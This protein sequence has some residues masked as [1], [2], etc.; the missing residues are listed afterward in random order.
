MR[1]DIPDQIFIKEMSLQ[2]LIFGG[3]HIC[4]ILNK[5]FLYVTAL[6]LRTVYHYLNYLKIFFF[7]LVN[8]TF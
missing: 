5:L 3:I 1:N 7:Q 8:G 2:Y 6:F 4:L